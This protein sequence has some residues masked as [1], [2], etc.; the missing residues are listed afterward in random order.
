MSDKIPCLDAALAY[1]EKSLDLGVPHKPHH[2]T[3]IVEAARSYAAQEEVDPES[4]KKDY[5]ASFDMGLTQSD[6]N[7]GYNDCL[8]YI[9]SQG[10]RIVK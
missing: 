5:G 2:A 4:L 9:K 10:W 8:D 7:I 1:F 6:K 3:A